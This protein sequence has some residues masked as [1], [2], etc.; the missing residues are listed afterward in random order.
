MPYKR[1]VD[2]VTDYELNEGRDS[3][4]LA[5]TAMTRLRNVLCLGLLVLL[6][7]LTTSRALGG[8]DSDNG[9]ANWGKVKQLSRGQEIQVVQNDA[10]SFQGELQSVSDEA[11][12]IHLAAGE[13]TF[14]KQSIL[15]VSSKGVSH[16]LRNA[17]LGA[18]A[19][20]GGGAGIGAAAANRNDFFGRGAYAAVGAV[21]GVVAGAAAG[22]L[23]PT[24]G[25]HEVYRAR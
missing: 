15:R 4:L 5:I 8:A 23:L 17:A 14:T 19:G 22:A 16:R 11:L 1:N 2:I 7:G 12:V 9:H 20:G 3:L 21:I 18:A 6:S 24:G 10:K 13:Q 25:W